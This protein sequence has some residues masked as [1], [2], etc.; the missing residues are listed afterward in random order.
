MGNK[1]QFTQ[2]QNIWRHLREKGQFLW[3][4]WK[5][6]VLPGMDPE[7][8]EYRTLDTTAVPGLGVRAFGAHLAGVPVGL[9]KDQSRWKQSWDNASGQPLQAGDPSIPLQVDVLKTHW[10]GGRPRHFSGD[11]EYSATIGGPIAGYVWVQGNPQ[12]A[13]Q[14]VDSTDAHARIVYPDGSSAEMI[15]VRLF[16][17]K[18]RTV[19]VEC[20]GLG[21]YNPDGEL[22]HADEGDRHVTAWKE[23]TAQD[24]PA[25]RITPLMLGRTEPAHRLAVSVPGVD[26][27]DT[28]HEIGMWVALPEEAVPWGSLTPDAA[29]VARML[30]DHGAITMDHGGIGSLV[31]ITG[32]DWKGVDF[33]KWAPT[34]DQFRRV[35]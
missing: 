24:G 2:D 16:N 6:Y 10:V 15:G 7:V 33:G 3:W 34:Y 27:P 35:T 25:G 17:S 14:I 32:A 4:K 11:V 5:G 21:R 20:R 12:P 19:R 29:R 13:N 26:A 9:P 23:E 8:E 1:F 22:T 18:G 31:E 28:M 30:V